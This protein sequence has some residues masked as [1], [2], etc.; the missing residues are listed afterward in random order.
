M[1]KK[2]SIWTLPLAAVTGALLAIYFLF[3][4]IGGVTGASLGETFKLIYVL[5][6]IQKNYVGEYSDKQV[7]EGAVAGAVK[8]LDDPY[9]VYLNK[10]DF[11]KLSAIT[12]GT[13]SGIGAVLGKE[14]DEFKVIAPM[15]GSPAAK[16]GIKAGDTILQIDGKS[17]EGMTLEELVNKIRGKSGTEVQLQIKHKAKAAGN[18]KAAG[19]IKNAVKGGSTAVK[20]NAADKNLV[21]VTVKRDKIEIKSVAGEM[22][23]GTKI[24]YIRISVFNEYTG[25]EFEKAYRKLEEEGMQATLLDLRQNPG[26]LL[27]ACTEVACHLIPEGPIVSITDKAGKTKIIDS[28]LKEVKYPLAVLVDNGSASASEI[29]SAAV[30]DTGA[31]RLFGVKTYGKGCVQSIYPTSM[32]TGLKLTT[33]MYYTPSGRS[34]H[35]IGVEP[36]VK[37]EL[38]ENATKD[39]QLEKAENYLKKMLK[40][41]KILPPAKNSKNSTETETAKAENVKSETAKAE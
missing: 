30:Q 23:P 32:D 8:A 41:G 1:K 24:G 17:V 2:V 38:P 12:E 27:S 29:V 34:I 13:F 28:D 39:V 26:G 9:S 18:A 35:K 31:G 14:G 10:D 20:G 36:D 25:A 6:S 16:A 33:A 40:E 22:L 15:D 7:M 4:A 11:E 5:Q 37:V 3:S 21:T 19:K